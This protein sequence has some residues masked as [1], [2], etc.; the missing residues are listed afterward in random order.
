MVPM[1]A[2]TMLY[3]KGTQE[4][5]HDVHVDW[6]IVDEHQV[7]EFLDQGW[8]RTPT[9][10]GKGEH[11]GEAE[12]RAAAARAEQERAERERQAAEDDARRADL[13]ARE[14]K[15]TAMQEEI[16]R[17]LAELE[18]AT[19]AATADAGKQAKQTKPAADGK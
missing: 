14:L 7:D 10:A 15:L 16:E 13:D 12:H 1:R 2:P 9:E 5:I 18:R 6:L 11:A 17:R 8:F 19:A 3:R 4:R